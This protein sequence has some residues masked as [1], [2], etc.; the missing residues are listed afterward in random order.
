MRNGGGGGAGGLELRA[1]GLH[2]PNKPP[3]KKKKKQ[4]RILL[5]FQKAQERPPKAETARFLEPSAEGGRAR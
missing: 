3:P 5:S 1:L 4:G 2:T